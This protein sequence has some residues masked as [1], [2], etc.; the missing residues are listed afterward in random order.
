MIFVKLIESDNK[1]KKWMVKLYN[2][3]NILIKT[4]HFGSKGSSD[5]TKHKDKNRK[6]NYL[7]RHKPNENWNDAGSA[8][9]WSRWLTWNKPSINESI[10]DIEKRFEIKFI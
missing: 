3:E 6:D 9:F 7:A 4:V 2:D 1:N 8:G 10:K 5:Y